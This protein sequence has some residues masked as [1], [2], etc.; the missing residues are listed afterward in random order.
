MLLY[1]YRATGDDEQGVGGSQDAQCES[2]HLA[3]CAG[4]GMEEGQGLL[5]PQGSSCCHYW[6]TVKA[7]VLRGPQ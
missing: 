5:L 6:I 1:L 7:A 3:G 4:G 2:H